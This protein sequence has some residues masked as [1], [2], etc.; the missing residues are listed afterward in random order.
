M[1]VEMPLA[2]DIEQQANPTGLFSKLS[3]AQATTIGGRK[4]PPLYDIIAS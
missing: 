2:K 1:P 3:E 4:T